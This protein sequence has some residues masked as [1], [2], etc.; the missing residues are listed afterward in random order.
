MG[1]RVHLSAAIELTRPHNCLLAGAAVA[2]GAIVA[3]GGFSSLELAKIALAFAVACVI[4]GA[5]N[6]INDYSDRKID[7]TNKP[8]RPIPSGRIDERAALSLSIGL[9]VVGIAV[10]SLVNLP[11]FLLACFNSL[12]LVA[13]AC[14]LKRCGLAGNIAIGYLVGSTFLF[15]GLTVGEVGAVGGAVGVLSAMAALSTAGRELVKDVEDMPGDR[16]LGART[17]PIKHGERAAAAL[18]GAL[19]LAA[20]LLSPLPYLLGILG[21]QYLW[22]VFCSVVVFVVGSALMIHDPARETAGRV[23]FMY[24]LAMGIGLLAFL[25]GALSAS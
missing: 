12:V 6:A 8:W 11:A 4:S 14:H 22:I 24:K 16:K 25:V 18:S 2:V 5:G 7:A 15:G 13:Y 10:S 3:S 23:S 19:V 17:F 20:V 9:F 1:E 21:W